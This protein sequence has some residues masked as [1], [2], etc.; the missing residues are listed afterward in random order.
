[1]SCIGLI[2]VYSATLRSGRPEMFFGKQMG[3]FLIGMTLLSIFT[4]LNYQIFSEYPKI[5]FAVSTFLLMLVIVAGSTS[6]GTK[7]WLT[8]GPIAFQP[9]EVS[10]LIVVLILAKVCDKDPKEMKQLKS[11]LLPFLIVLWHIGLILCQP[12]FGSTLV[13]FPILAGIL[14]VSGARLMHL[15]LIFFLGSVAGSMVLLHT[16]L[17]LSPKF[18][19]LHPFLNYVY[20]SM[21]IGKEF[22]VIQSVLGLACIFFWWLFKQLR[23]RI[24]GFYFICAFFLT[25]LGFIAS[26][27]FTH[28]LKDYQRKRL[29]VFFNPG[30]DPLGSGYHVIQSEIALGSGKIFGKGLF[31]GTQGR[32]GFLP[33]NHTDFVF[34]V[35]GEE[36]GFITSAFVLLLYFILIWRSVAIAGD[37]RDRFGTLVS[38][39]I[40]S[41]LAFYTILNLSMVM[42]LAPV[43]GLPLPFLSYG[44]SALVSSLAATGLLLS[45][46]FR[47]YAH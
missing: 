30:I 12:D 41:M 29:V 4:T 5:L 34:S 37:A 20:K 15:I 31:S 17:S 43:T 46:H 25:M 42:G 10:K 40:G 22:A 7:A 35:L 33:E 45:I 16:A 3:A 32:L 13:Y 28:S 39:G 44:G 14:F 36:L 2:V 9:S 18:L 11:L 24:P 19:E 6:H 27:V 1:M 38:V 21:S 47:R 26:S 8:V 23:F